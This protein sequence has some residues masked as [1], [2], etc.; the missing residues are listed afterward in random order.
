MSNWDYA[1]ETP[2]QNFRSAMTVA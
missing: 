2:T 1:N